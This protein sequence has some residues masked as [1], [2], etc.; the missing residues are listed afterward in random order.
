MVLTTAIRKGVDPDS[1]SYVSKPLSIDDPVYGHWD[2]KTFGDTYSGSMSLT[3]AT[4]ASDNSVY[5]QLILDVGPKEVCKTAKMLGILTKLDCFPAE[6][7]GGLTNGV[8]TLEMAAAYSTLAS[9]GVRHR[10]TGIQKVVF[11]DGTSEKLGGRKGKRV[12]T[13][14]QAAEV[15]RI[16][17]MN[18]QSGTGTAAYYGCPAAGKTGTTD[19][20]ADAWFVGYTPKLSTAVWVGYPNERIAMPGAQGGTYAAPVWYTY[21]LNAHGDDC[22]DFPEP[23]TPFESSPFFGKYATTGAA[24]TGDY[25]YSDPNYYSSP[26]GSTGGTEY[27][28][29]LYE[30]PPQDAPEATPEEVT[31]GP[32]GNPDNPNGNGPQAEP[33]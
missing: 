31:P 18:M 19:E 1:T 29:N 16:L 13:D 4:L 5:A 3:S 14:G 11:S 22:S 20:A 2:V 27:D 9:G 7:L 10:P 8:T 15:T 28:P 26:D 30:S 6:G 12:L 25:G 17:E 33:G 24:G 32:P 23:E 21:M